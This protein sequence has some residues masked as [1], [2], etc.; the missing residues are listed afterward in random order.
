MRSKIVKSRITIR[1]TVTKGEFSMCCV[2]RTSE[3]KA[4]IGN[5]LNVKWGTSYITCGGPGRRARGATFGS[6]FA[7]KAN[8]DIF[9]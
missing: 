7:I 6:D 4:F 3:A 1:F 8:G 5:Q 2:I 9:Q